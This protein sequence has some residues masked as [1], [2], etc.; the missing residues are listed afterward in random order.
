MSIAAA[1]RRIVLCVSLAAAAGGAAAALPA[2]TVRDLA[3]GDNDAKIRAIND[4][5]GRQRPKARW[6]CSR[7][8]PP[9]K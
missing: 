6:R 7:R 3:F 4:A 5:G 1:L 2:A 9:T 8:W